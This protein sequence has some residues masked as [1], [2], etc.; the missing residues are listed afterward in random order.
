MVYA[1]LPTEQV[2]LPFSIKTRHDRCFLGKSTL[3]LFDPDVTPLSDPDVSLS[4]KNAS[5]ALF[6]LA[7]L[8]ILCSTGAITV[9]N[10]FKGM[11]LVDPNRQT[12]QKLQ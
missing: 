6:M 1:G 8:S 3:P 11:E 10:Y 7:V 9:S 4:V 12:D 2:R 5:V